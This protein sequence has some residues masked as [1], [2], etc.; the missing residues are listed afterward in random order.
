MKEVKKVFL[1][2][3]EIFGTAPQIKWAK[4][5]KKN[6]I[7][8]IS[9]VIYAIDNKTIKQERDIQNLNA[10]NKLLTVITNMKQAH[11]LIDMSK[12]N[13][14]EKVNYLHILEDPLW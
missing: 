6:Y 5:L 4:E 8:E 1:T 14:K 2:E 11:Y 9:N 3:N 13:I 12:M 7:T 10:L